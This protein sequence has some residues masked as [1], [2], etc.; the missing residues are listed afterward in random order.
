MVFIPEWLAEIMDEDRAR[1]NILN[2][3]NPIY[4][5]AERAGPARTASRLVYSS[6]LGVLQPVYDENGRRI[7]EPSGA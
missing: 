4:Q 3:D 7:A 6:R 1:M 5:I 2:P